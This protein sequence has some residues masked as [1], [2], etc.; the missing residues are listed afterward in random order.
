EKLPDGS[1][2]V[3]GADGAPNGF[4]RE[5]GAMGLLRA[6]LPVLSFEDKVEGLL[7]VLT[8]MAAN[9]LT[10]IEMLDNE[11]PDS[12]ALFQELERRGELPLRVR[13]APW[14]LAK[15]GPEVLDEVIAL[16]GIRGRRFEVRGAKLMIDGTV[17]N[18]TA[19][20]NEP[21]TEGES[22]A[23]LWLAPADYAAALARLHAAGV[24][25]TTHAIGDRGVGFVAESI[26][27]LPEG[28][29]AHRI[30][31]IEALSDADLERLAAS[32][33]AA[34]MQPT[35]CTHFV[36]PD[37]T[38]AWSRRLGA[39]RSRTHTFRMRD[40]LDRGVLLALGSDWPI[41]PYDPREILAD[42]QARRRTARPGSA[43]ID[44]QRL[45]ARE[46]LEGYTV[47]VHRSTGGTGGTLALGQLA[48]VTVLS[49]DPLTA[50]PETLLAAEV[51]GTLLGGETA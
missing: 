29:P 33:A 51:L 46:A 41:A 2:V 35:H 49:V 44:A 43:V 22:T 11:D 14:F 32:G 39:E 48:D 50:T 30:E 38:D 21:D 7:A 34:S 16:Q 23:S 47:S 1:E 27:A 45:T 6:H 12:I 4:L 5:L 37:R 25:T 28:G 13:I 18:G 36:R 19:W 15:H 40:V 26:A 20:L 9:G 24:T 8:D 3:A 31:H 42:A 17:D 10:G